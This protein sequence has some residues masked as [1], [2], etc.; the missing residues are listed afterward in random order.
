VGAA[1][2]RD[3][4][5]V[6]A[7]VPAEAASA[8]GESLAGAVGVADRLPAEVAGLLLGPAKE[9]FTS[10]L[11]VAAVMGAV[12][13][14]ALALVA[15]MVFRTL[16]PYGENGQSETLEPSAELADGCLVEA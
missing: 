7:Q 16:R 14:A 6:P 2:Y 4:V 5:D 11:H 15:G 8:A 1:V 9:A 13:F 3:Q 10:G 12:A